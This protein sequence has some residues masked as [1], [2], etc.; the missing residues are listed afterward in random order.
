MHDFEKNIII[1]LGSFMGVFQVFGVAMALL[2]M[3]LLSKQI[4]ER[5]SQSISMVKI[6]GFTD[7]EIGKL[8][9]FST[10]VVVLLSLLIAIPIVDKLLNWVFSVYLYK[11]ITGYFPCN[12]APSI[13]LRA[14]LLGAITYGA[15]VVLQLR[16]INKIPKSDAL[17]NVE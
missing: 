5:N 13:Y 9:I 7:G 8:Y 15:V 17:K 11:L 6:L 3:Y 2:L 12:V 4:I 10:T 1:L 16:R 14:F